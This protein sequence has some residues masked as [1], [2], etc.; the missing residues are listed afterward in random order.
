MN[1]KLVCVTEQH[2]SDLIK[3]VCVT[4]SVC[5]VMERLMCD[6]YLDFVF[7]LFTVY[8]SSYM[9]VADTNADTHTLQENLE[10]ISRI[11]AIRPGCDVHSI[12][13]GSYYDVMYHKASTDT[14]GKFNSYFYDDLYTGLCELLDEAEVYNY[15]DEIVKG[16]ETLFDAIENNVLHFLMECNAAEAK[17]FRQ[18]FVI[19]FEVIRGRL[20]MYIV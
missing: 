17:P 11:E 4:E 9:S 3:S 12:M 5:D 8:A 20:M 7:N 19:Y 15:I 14:F 13:V 6:G 1:V 10:A 18:Y 2:V 16:L